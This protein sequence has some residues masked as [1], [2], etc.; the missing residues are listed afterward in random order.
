MRAGGA[1]AHARGAPRLAVTVTALGIAQIVSWGTL[2]YSITVLAPS[3]RADLGVGD[4]VLFGGFTAG[5]VVSGAASPWIGRRIDAFGGRT[6]LGAGSLL[7]AL[8]LTVLALAQGPLS[9]T[10][11]W[12]IAGA[13][14][15]ATLYDPAFA[16]LSTFAGTSYRRAVTALTLFG[17]FASTVFWP[18]SQ[19]L[20]QQVGWRGAFGCYAVLSLVVCL[21]LHV[22][23][24]PR[25][26]NRA[27]SSPKPRA[28]DV[29]PPASA[30]AYFWLATALALASLIAASVAP[31]LIGLMTAKGLTIAEAVAV[32]AL[33]GPMQVAGR[34]VEFAFA[35]R[36]RATA[37]GTF[38]FALFAAS[39]ASLL[40]VD[41]RIGVALVFAALYGLSN[42]VLTIV[43]GVVPAELFGRAH[44]GALLGRLAMPQLVARA[45]APLALALFFAV[46]PD[47]TRSPWLLLGIG[48]GALA[49]YRLAIAS[50]R[51][52]DPT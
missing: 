35:R 51:A 11:G 31:H 40:L 9:L 48:V 41:A 38:A 21:P 2:Y 17:G 42:G 25:G 30:R 46:D 20:Q 18:A 5:L 16:A 32:G 3:I 10:L 29:V 23:Y 14:M 4:V 44:Y 19:L 13:A 7:G 43:R 22:I 8:A 36:L 12:L 6:V 45:I 49:A 33:I 1:D 24:V 28:A 39:L 52:P 15:A 34:I 37:V 50:S 47:R 27:A 26:G